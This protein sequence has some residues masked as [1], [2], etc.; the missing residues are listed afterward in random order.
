MIGIQKENNLNKMAKKP[1]KLDKAELD[2][3]NAVKTDKRNLLVEL[4]EIKLL[5]LQLEERIDRA[6]ENK[7]RIENFELSLS[8]SLNQKY[9]N[10]EI[11][12]ITGKIS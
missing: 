7:K 6:K 5:E 3:L 4:G 2:Q 1:K 10:I 12:L 8:N 11:D 9:G